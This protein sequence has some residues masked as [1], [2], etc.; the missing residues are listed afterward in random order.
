MVKHFKIKHQDGS[1]RVCELT[2]K[3]GKIETPFF[4]PVA[5]KTSV[6]YISS[7]DLKSMGN[8][9]VISNA[10]VLF[11][12]PGDDFF[13]KVGGIKKLM[14][15]HGINAT[16]SGGFQMYKDCFLIKTTKDGVW[17]RSPFDGKKF[18][19]TPEHDMEI[20]NNIDSDIAMCLD[21]MPLIEHSKNAIVNAIENTT[22]WAKRCKIHHNKLNTDSK[23]KL[24]PQTKR[25]LL[26]AITQ[27]G[28][29]DE[30]RKKS[31]T[32]LKDL[33]VDGFS[34]GGLA[35]GEGKED[36]LRMVK[37]HKSIVP[38]DKPTYLMGLGSPVELIESI[39]LGV[40]MFDSRFPTQ[41]ARRGT[42]FTS[43]GKLRLMRKEYKHDMGPLDSK[44]DC[45]VCKNYSRAFIRYQLGQKEGTGYRLATYHQLYYL[46]RLMENSRKA[47]KDGKF[48]AFK[49][50]FIGAYEKSD[51]ENVLKIK[52][53]KLRIKSEM[54]EIAA[55][56]KAIK[57]EHR[58][59]SVEGMVNRVKKLKNDKKA[60]E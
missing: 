52:K 34:C 58:R 43:F 6:K 35:L 15:Y 22:A 41:N 3:S 9:A 11:L 55:K 54:K 26:F 24:K 18:F 49:K 5:T 12:R 57:D 38:E 16:D 19:V 33:D 23:G 10:F 50:K 4:M 20:Q 30:L 44:C 17:F 60:S 40:D 59:K 28:I 8:T 46:M 31:C 13:K 39:N 53:D 37:I 25:Q 48:A 2:T 32:E 1:A 56:K 14:N 36:M 21:T 29:H 7:E 42:I 27:G 51:K 45:F 47:I